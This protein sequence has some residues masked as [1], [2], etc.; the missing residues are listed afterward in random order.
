MLSV[1]ESVIQQGQSKLFAS[2][3]KHKRGRIKRQVLVCPLSKGGLGF[4]VLELQ[5]KHYT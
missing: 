2:L 4:H 3:W 1:P 5:L